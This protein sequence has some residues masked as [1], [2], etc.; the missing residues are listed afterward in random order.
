MKTKTKTQIVKLKKKEQTPINIDSGK[1]ICSCQKEIEQLKSEIF[2]IKTFFKKEIEN[3]KAVFSSSNNEESSS[4][5]S[6]NDR[7]V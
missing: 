2:S 7:L 6:V 1:C 3:L 4:I 5:K